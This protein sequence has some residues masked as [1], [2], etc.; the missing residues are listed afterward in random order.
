MP[1]IVIAFAILTRNTSM[2]VL[3]SK[4]RCVKSGRNSIDHDTNS[5]ILHRI[6]SIAWNL[7]LCLVKSSNIHRDE[8][9]AYFYSRTEFGKQHLPHGITP[10]WKQLSTNI[11][12]GIGERENLQHVT[13]KFKSTRF[14]KW[15]DLLC[16]PSMCTISTVVGR[17]TAITSELNAYISSI[18]FSTI[19]TI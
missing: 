4:Y 11:C 19:H 2:P 7:A 13:T 5:S 8:P 18:N 17:C 14:D 1:S 16:I 12:S 3:L 6:C 9:Q 15:L 10:V